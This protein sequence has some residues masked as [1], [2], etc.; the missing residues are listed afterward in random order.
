MELDH[1][2]LD[3]AESWMLASLEAHIQEHLQTKTDSEEWFVS[4]DP[5]FDESHPVSL[6]DLA[7]GIAKSPD[8]WEDQVAGRLQIGKRFADH[9]GTPGTLDPLRDA[10]EV[11]HLVIDD[12]DDGSL[13]HLG[14]SPKNSS[15]VF[16]HCG[17]E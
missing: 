2:A 4:S 11:S 7:D 16:M 9:R 13:I 12:P 17:Q 15:S 3:D 10:S 6:P 5:V 8:A 1:F 14:L